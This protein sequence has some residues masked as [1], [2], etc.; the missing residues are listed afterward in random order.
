MEAMTTASTAPCVRQSRLT[1]V[2][3][4]VQPDGRLAS[5]AGEGSDEAFEEIVRRHRSSLVSFAARIAPPGS[6]DDVVQDSMV[7]AH[8]ALARGDSP[9]NPRAWLYRI[10]RNTALNELRDHRDHEHLDENY[11]GVEQPPQ[12]AERRQQ[13]ARLFQSIQ[14][15]PQAQR[16]ALVARELEGKGHDEIAESLEVSPGAV[17]Q[18]IFR[19]RESLRAAAGLLIPMQLLRAIALSGAAEPVAGGVAGAGIG[20]TAAKLG[21][22]AVLATGAIVAG[23]D[24]TGT[25]KVGPVGTQAKE[26]GS[27]AETRADGGSSPAT[28]PVSEAAAHGREA[29]GRL[30]AG[31]KTRQ[32][33]AGGLDDPQFGSEPIPGPGPGGDGH[34]GGGHRDG[35]RRGYTGDGDQPPP[36][37]DGGG[38]GGEGG[39]KPPPPGS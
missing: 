22:G 28:T 14:A 11:D 26:S 23:L 2:M 38:G 30:T 15:L 39:Y 12:A 37:E 29:A 1:G 17:R 5:L 9:D 34:A 32:G 27:A 33:G 16:E 6:A 13:T 20:L 31:V 4:R 35:D 36:P 7:K 24:A 19:A 10:V 8:R 21:L 3:L 18:L 25:I